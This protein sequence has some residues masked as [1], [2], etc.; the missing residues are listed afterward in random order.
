MKKDAQ[1]FKLTAQHVEF[2][3]ACVGDSARNF[4]DV[5][6]GHNHHTAHHKESLSH[7]VLHDSKV[8]LIESVECVSAQ[9]SKLG[10]ELYDVDVYVCVYVCVCV[11]MFFGFASC[12]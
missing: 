10:H 6:R 8:V 5:R 1:H 9:T 3:S 4:V 7:T 12:L 11:C 2:A